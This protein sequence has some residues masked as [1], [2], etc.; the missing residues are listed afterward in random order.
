MLNPSGSSSST[1]DCGMT[2]PLETRFFT[3]GGLI[4]HLLSASGMPRF[5]G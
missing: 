5:V 1:G 3:P 2:A 4:V